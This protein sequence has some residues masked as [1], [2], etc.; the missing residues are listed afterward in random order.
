MLSTKRN[1]APTVYQS[2]MSL[3]LSPAVVVASA[4][5]LE[6]EHASGNTMPDAHAST[7]DTKPVKYINA[8]ATGMT[9]VMALSSCPVD[10]VAGVVTS[11]SEYPS[12]KTMPNMHTM[13]NDAVPDKHV[14]A[15][16]A[17]NSDVK[18]MEDTLADKED[19]G[20]WGKMNTVMGKGSNTPP[21]VQ[22]PG[23]PSTDNIVSSGV[24][25]NP[26]NTGSRA[27]YR[28][29]Q[30]AETMSVPAPPKHTKGGGTIITLRPALPVIISS[31]DLKNN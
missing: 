22:Y 19:W 3:L 10:I 9:N 11:E 18:E 16:N 21:V 30:T 15:I 26:K 29:P 6:S 12:D 5:A 4:G 20:N 17:G 28:G 27:T 23:K 2:V 1:P 25:N 13:T 8:D 24:N 14:D 31:P 7:S